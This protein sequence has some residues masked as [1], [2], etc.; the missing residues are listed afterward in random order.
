MTMEIVVPSD[1]VGD[2]MEGNNSRRGKIQGVDPGDEIQT[3][4]AYVSIAEV[5]TYAADLASMT[6]G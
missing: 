4:S 3:I 1:H 5:L 6:G 2:I